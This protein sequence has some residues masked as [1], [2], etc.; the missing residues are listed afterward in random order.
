MLTAGAAAAQSPLDRGPTR[1]FDVAVVP[2]V[3]LGFNAIRVWQKD[4]VA[5]QADTGKCVSYAMGNAPN[6]VLDVTAPLGRYFG[7]SVA[8]TIGQPQRV[9]CVQAN[10]CQAT[11]TQRLT[12]LRGSGMLL[13]RL[14]PQAP[15]FLGVGYAISQSNPGPLIWQ[16]STVVEKGP[17]AELAFDFALGEQV[18]FRIAWWNYWFSVNAGLG[19]ALGVTPCTTDPSDGCFTPETT[20]HDQM[21]TFGARIRLLK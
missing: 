1:G 4:T 21:F 18:G 7:L 15:V 11:S 3:S 9:T 16:D 20:A 10:A 14:K 19:S 2:S 5:C 8:G 13:F 6:F 17:V 12:V